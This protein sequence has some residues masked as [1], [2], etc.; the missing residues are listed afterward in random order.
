MILFQPNQMRL[1]N[2]KHYLHSDEELFFVSG[3]NLDYL[4][5]HKRKISLAICYE[6]SVPEHIENAVK[7]RAE[8]YVASVAKSESGVEKAIQTLSD[9]AKRHSMIVLMSNSVGPSE[10]FE[11]AG[12]TSIWNRKGLLLGQL[13]NSQEGILIVDCETEDLHKEHL[14]K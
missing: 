7:N 3:E 9:I 1:I 6:I 5:T 4:E 8:I 10:D 2:S 12:K 14:Q 11:S 13:D